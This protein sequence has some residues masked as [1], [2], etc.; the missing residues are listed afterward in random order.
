M[1]S[2]ESP[3][4]IA[5]TMSILLMIP[6]TEKDIRINI[7]EIITLWNSSVWK[8]ENNNNITSAIIR[9]LKNCSK[10]ILLMLLKEIALFSSGMKDT[11]TPV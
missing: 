3:N 6:L 9:M 10:K 1:N 11:N 5:E 4:K 2:I 8:N 7:V